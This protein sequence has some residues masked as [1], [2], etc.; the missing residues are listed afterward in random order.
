MIDKMKRAGIHWLAFGVESASERVRAQA[1]KGYSQELI[2]STI[3]RVRGAGIN[4]IANYIFGLPEDDVDTMR[5]TLDAAIDL[6]TEFANFYCAMA[7]P[8]SPLYRFA[9]AENW[10]LPDSWG[11]YSQ[12]SVETLPLPT[13][14]LTSGEVLRFRDEAFH[15]YYENPRYLDMITQRFGVETADHVRAMTGRRLERKYS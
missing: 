10:R 1:D 15:E 3:E 8:G 14:R 6:N 12:H 5:E 11:G 4:V 9:V 7:Y 2:Y 13:K